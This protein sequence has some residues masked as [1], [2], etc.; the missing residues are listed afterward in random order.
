MKPDRTTFLGGTDVSALVGV[1]PYKTAH[2][3]YLEKIG[4]LPDAGETE[5][6][7]WGKLLEPI[8][9]SEFASATGLSIEK[10]EFVRDAEHAFLGASP[11][12][13]VESDGILEVKTSGNRHMWGPDGSADAPEH[14]VAQ[15]VW[16]A[17]LT[18]RT[19]QIWIAA[20][21]GG[22]EMRVFRL[23]WDPGLYARM[24]NEAVRFWKEHVEPRVPPKMTQA[25]LIAA[26]EREE[27]DGT[28]VEGTEAHAGMIARLLEIKAEM[29]D[30]EQ[31]KESL[32]AAIK[33]A[34]GTASVLR[35]CGYE[36]VWSKG[37]SVSSVDWKGVAMELS[38]SPE[39]VGL[40]TRRGTTRR[41]FT[42]RRIQ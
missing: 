38:P 18:G 2:S 35:A 15:A 8:V 41:V 24:R 40:Y 14:C 3:L 30:L 32:E 4:E 19:G 25:E 11:D 29:A 31:E 22:Q 17:G 16:Y 20:L 28:T 39:L 10:A 33:E 37:R 13:Y 9:A 6:M 21:L 1:N 27:P 34:V 36:A 23:P 5:P 7:R 42:L 12:Y 26:L